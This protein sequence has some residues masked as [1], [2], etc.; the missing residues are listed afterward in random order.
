MVNSAYAEEQRC[1]GFDT[2]R[3]GLSG[4]FARRSVLPYGMR[5]QARSRPRPERETAEFYYRKTHPRCRQRPPRLTRPETALRCPTL[6]PRA[7]KRGLHRPWRISAP[8]HGLFSR[9]PEGSSSCTRIVLHPRSS[10]AAS[11]P[12]RW[13]LGSLPLHLS[14]MP[15]IRTS[16]CQRPSDDNKSEM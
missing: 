15:T 12:T 5:S 10:V 6:R 11:L 9:S 4:R 1:T 16:A 13:Y 3:G 14:E 8:I 2:T 7:R